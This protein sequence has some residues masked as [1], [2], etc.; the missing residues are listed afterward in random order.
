MAQA[1]VI[2]DFDGTLVDSAPGILAGMA[3]ALAACGLEP[4]I[5]LVPQIIGPPLTQTLALASG[6]DTPAVL[7]Q[8]AAEFKRFYDLE[9]YRDTLPYAGIDGA[10]HELV[11]TGIP[12]HIAT[13]KRGHPTRLILDHLGWTT[14]FESVY[15]LDECPECSEKGDMLGK[16][17][18]ERSLAPRITLYVGD[19]DG[20]AIAAKANQ[21]HFLHAAWGYG[22]SGAE[23]GAD[24][25]CNSTLQLP[26]AVRDFFAQ[27]QTCQ[28][29]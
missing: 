19:T 15:C 12:L 14:L 8:L 9:A 2:F 18:G 3:R 29:N 28:A 7:M 22:R 20:D 26:D 6:I 24:C 16:L 23:V 13:N 17:I 5:P 11:L 1:S 21:L 4:R 10:L 27:G 25:I